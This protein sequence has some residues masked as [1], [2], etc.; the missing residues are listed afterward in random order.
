[1]NNAGVA[2]HGDL[3]NIDVCNS[4]FEVNVNGTIFNFTE[5]M[6]KNDMIW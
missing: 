2:T 4:T 1:M 6:I 5:Y 3:F